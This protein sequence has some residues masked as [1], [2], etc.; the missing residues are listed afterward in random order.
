MPDEAH[1]RGELIGEN[2]CRFVAAIAVFVFENADAT[3]AGEFLEFA[4]EVSARG[5]GDIKA[6]FIVQCGEHRKVYLGRTA[7][8]FDHKSGWNLQRG[9]VRAEDA[10]T[11]QRKNEREPVH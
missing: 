11:Q 10:A 9:F 4:V 7:D 1:G 5:L 2:G 6:S 8:A 3:G